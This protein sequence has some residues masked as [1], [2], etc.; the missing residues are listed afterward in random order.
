MADATVKAMRD[1]ALLY[2]QR[3]HTTFAGADIAGVSRAGTAYQLRRLETEFEKFQSGQTAL[4]A[5]ANGDA[6]KEPLLQE[7]IAVDAMYQQLFERFSVRGEDIERTQ[8]QMLFDARIE[9]VQ[10]DKPRRP[11]DGLSDFDG[12]HQKWPAF[13]DLF[14]ALVIDVGVSKLE[15][16]LLLQA[17]FDLAWASLKEIY[18][19]TYSIIQSLIDKMID[20]E[21]ASG[22]SPQDTRRVVDTLR[23]TLRQLVSMDVPTAH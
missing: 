3:C 15:C 23:S 19:D 7:L 1:T 5:I 11:L 4:L 8:T 14:K 21:P 16:L 12:T 6:E 22:K 10:G 2:I 17:S 13:R 9:R 20:L 18:D